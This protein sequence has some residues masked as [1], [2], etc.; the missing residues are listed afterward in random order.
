MKTIRVRIAVC[1]APDGSWSSC[2]WHVDIE[3]P[4]RL[5]AFVAADARSDMP[6]YAAVH[7]IEA[8]V[9]LPQTL[10]GKVVP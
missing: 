7:F 4:P 6:D 2:G 8:N 9:P 3:R 1:V 5:D 10:D